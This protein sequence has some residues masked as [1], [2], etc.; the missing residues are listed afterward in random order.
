MEDLK[1]ELDTTPNELRNSG[2]YDKQGKEIP[3]FQW[4]GLLGDRKYSQIYLLSTRKYLFSTIWL[5]LNQNTDDPEDKHP[6][7]FESM[8]F[9][10]EDGVVDYADGVLYMANYETLR[11][12]KLG[13]FKMIAKVLAKEAVQKLKKM[14]KSQ[15]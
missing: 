12:A 6:L 8:A 14:G 5:G 11:E 10:K 15:G 1:K 4:A 7:I 2:K 13:H 3:L 9:R